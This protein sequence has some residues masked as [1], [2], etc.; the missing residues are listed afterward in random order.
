MAQQGRKKQGGAQAG[1][2]PAPP[3]PQ[4][5]DDLEEIGLP[6][7]SPVDDLVVL[8]GEDDA[9]PP[10]GEA[11]PG[12]R[13]TDMD[14]QLRIMQGRHS[15][16]LSAKDQMINSLAQ[17]IK[18][19]RAA[20]G[21]MSRAPGDGGGVQ[22]PPSLESSPRFQ[23]LK[24]E[25]PDIFEGMTELHGMV[26]NQISQIGTKLGEIENLQRSSV[27][28]TAEQ[29]EGQFWSGF[30]SAVPDWD[31]LRYD[32]M[33]QQWMA[34]RERIGGKTRSEIWMEAYQRKDP[35]AAVQIVAAMREDLQDSGTLPQQRGL[36]SM[37]SV[38]PP[39]NTVPRNRR[40]GNDNQFITQEAI[41]KFYAD[42]NNGVIPEETAKKI[43]A[44]IDKYLREGRV[45]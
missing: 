29:A 1:Q 31:A 13:P 36:P 14:Q 10:G 22:R 30:N 26:S 28:Q 43:E 25:F 2:P 19:M 42:W 20:I 23:K 27:R 45:V 16:E 39:T 41:H 21:N 7:G 37:G 44:R 5:Q 17:D 33:V 32:P 38:S 3:Q 40:T 9:R 4:N 6:G 15:A 8:L 18:E 24:D 35:S 34:Q 11:I 12:A